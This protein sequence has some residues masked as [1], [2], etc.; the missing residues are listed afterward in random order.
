MLGAVFGGPFPTTVYIA[1]IGSKWMGAGRGY[2]ILNGVVYLLAAM[3]GLVAAMSAIIP[4]AV[5]APIL[6]F[7]GVSMVSTAFQSNET[8]YFPA[9]A[10]S[11]LPYV[12]NYLMTRF[13]GKAGEVVEGISTG[14]VPL[15]QGA[16]FTGIILGAITVFIIDRNFKRLFK[17]DTLQIKMGYKFSF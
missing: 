9:V 7:V 5:V 16:M 6:V 1:S 10:I 14:I 17:K 8:K 3:F 15:G 2:S 11:M 13:N 12:S 4:V